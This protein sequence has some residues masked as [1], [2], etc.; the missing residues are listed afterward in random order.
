MKKYKVKETEIRV[1]PIEQ[2]GWVGFGWL[3][4][5][6]HITLQSTHL[7]IDEESAMV[8]AFEHVCS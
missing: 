1:F 4:Q 6:P 8:E 5:T 7:H 3:V 2:H